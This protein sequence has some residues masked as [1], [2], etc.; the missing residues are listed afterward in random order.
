MAQTL[1]STVRGM[2]L[3][4]GPDH[5]VSQGFERYTMEDHRTWATL[6]GRQRRLLVGRV[7]DEFLA[8]LDRLG[9]GASGIPD[10]DAVN[11]R[12]MAATG[13]RVVA[14]PGLVPDAVFFEHLAN[15]RFPAGF[16]IRAPHEIDYIEEPDVFHDVFGHVPL[17]MRQ[18]YAD[19]LEAYGKAG[20]ALAG[21]GALHRLARLYWY[22]VEFGL[23]RTAE[24]LRI[25]GAGI[26]SSP[27]ETVFALESTSPD[28]IGFDLARTMRTRYRIDDYQES[29]MVLD[30]FAALPSLAHDHL[31]AVIAA[32]GEQ[33]DIEPRPNGS[34][35]PCAQPR[36]RPPPPQAARRRG[37]PARG[38]IGQ[39]PPGK[40]LTATIPHRAR[41]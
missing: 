35:R 27:G 37:A 11:E 13:W 34:R 36:R 21:E 38:G 16:W 32:I 12:L 8:G 23:M 15:R 22:T 9:I 6:Y 39:A 20:A 24:G 4:H 17:L 25:F 7:V 18:D 10:F 26:A 3:Q 28:R 31:A 33:P 2:T 19:Y 1:Q 14:V 41:H 5:I 30:G 29:Y 40:R